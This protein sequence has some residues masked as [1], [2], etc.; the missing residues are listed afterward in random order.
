[1]AAAITNYMT[2]DANDRVTGW[3]QTLALAQAAADATLASQPPGQKIKVAV[4]LGTK[5]TA[6][7]L[8]TW[9]PV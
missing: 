7:A 5:Q 4:M 2:I 1:M 3:Y 9:T 8:V 6:T